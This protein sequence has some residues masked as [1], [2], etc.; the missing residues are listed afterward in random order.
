MDV[1]FARFILPVAAPLIRDG[2]IAI[3]DG[4]I[5]SAGPRKEVLEAAGS[6]ARVLDLGNAIVIPGLVNAHTHVELSCLADDPP[7][8]E[9]YASWVFDLLSKKEKMDRE[10]AATAAETALAKLRSRGT[11]AIGDVANETW[12]APAIARSGLHGIVFHEIYG[13]NSARAESL[14]AEAA[15]RLEALG[16]DKD[17]AQ[18]EGRVRIALS[19]HAPHTTSAPLLRA[20]AGRSAACGDPFSIHVAES[21]AETAFLRDGGG[22]L[23]PFYRDRGF[24]HEGW[25][26]PGS[27]PVGYLHRLGVLSPRTMAVHCVHLTQQDHSLLQAG[28]VTVVTCPRSNRRLNVG[29]APIPKLMKA[30]VPV[31]LGTDSLASAP[32]LD[33]FAEM[34]ALCEEHPSLSPAAVLRMATLN[35]ARILGV[36]D[37]LG[38]IEPGKLAELI[39][40]PAGEGDR[41]P[42]ETVCSAPE[43]VYLLSEA[44]GEAVS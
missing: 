21:Q 9:D 18:A 31:A 2:A 22:P 5:A 15:G 36:D 3:E 1:Y 23:A 44:P 34:A 24:L 6:D 28:R 11:V 42:L 30:G 20:L 27:S 35:G 43:Q 14:I 40:V 4:R 29:V 7:A 26:P 10:A 16:A 17:V 12:S 37:R 39:V 33:L 38:S 8:G 25:K 13:T 19:P 32:D 41:S